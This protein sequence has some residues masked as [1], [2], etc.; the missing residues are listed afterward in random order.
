[1]KEICM[2]GFN[3]QYVTM[4][5]EGTA[6]PGDL[7]VMCADNTVKK[8]A[9]GKFAGVVRSMRG[10]YALVQTGGFAVLHYSGSDP[11]VGFIKLAA[12]SKADAVLSE[13]GREVLATEVNT[14]AKNVG[15]LF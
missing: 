13:S 6:E 5:C 12:D 14:T 8:A 2:Q 9:S 11:Q 3:S 4:K 1:M 7:V 15:I 10:E